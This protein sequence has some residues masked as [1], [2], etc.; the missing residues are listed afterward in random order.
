MDNLTYWKDKWIDVGSEYILNKKTTNES[1]EIWN[2]S[3]KNYDET[4]DMDR[5]DT[6]INKLENEGYINEDSVVLDLGC[7][8]GSY[9]IPLSGI[10]KS[11]DALDYSD[12]MLKVLQRKISKNNIN[13]IEIIKNNWS[14]LEL[15]KEGMYKKYDFVV[16]SLNPGSYNP[17]NLLK[18]NEASKY[19]CCYISTDG[20][21]KNERLEEAD[22]IILGRKITTPDISNI[23]YPFN[24]LY[25]SNYNPSIFYVPCNWI[26]KSDY[27]KAIKK[28]I[29]RYKDYV[30]I[31]KDIEGNIKKFVED[32]IIEDVF[33][34]ESKNTLGVITWKVID[35]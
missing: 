26:V 14:D 35:S 21:G 33:L 9:S 3:S 28:L 30:D 11:V 4:V 20:K 5:I 1:I 24:V 31:N 32:N 10:C 13:N 18:I 29:N 22:N 17:T 15:K 16:C 2:K 34:E 19:G 27:D 25:F 6:V 23:I 12:G 8:T 7:G